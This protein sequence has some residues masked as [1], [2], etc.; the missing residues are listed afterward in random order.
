M[1]KAQSKLNW[2]ISVCAR[3][4]NLMSV[5]GGRSSNLLFLLRRRSLFFASTEASSPLPSGPE[6]NEPEVVAGPPV[7]PEAFGAFPSTLAVIDAATAA[8]LAAASALLNGGA[9]DNIDE[10]DEEEDVGSDGGAFTGGGGG[11]DAFA[12]SSRVAHGGGFA[13]R[14]FLRFIPRGVWSLEP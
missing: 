5:S 12:S 11:G 7:S 4:R 10:D 9:D 6:V 13:L 2:C 8:A 3:A 1:M 14:T